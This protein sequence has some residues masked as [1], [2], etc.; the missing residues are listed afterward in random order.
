MKKDIKFNK[1]IK[2]LIYDKYKKKIY[3]YKN[4]KSNGCIGDRTRGLSNAN[5]T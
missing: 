4:K 5:R 3:K 1:K 2:V